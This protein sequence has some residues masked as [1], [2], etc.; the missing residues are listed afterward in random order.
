MSE[1][2]FKISIYFP[3]FFAIILILG[4]LL[5]IKLAGVSVYNESIL[6]LKPAKSNKFS[7][8]LE[9]IN[10][11]Y[12]DSVNNQ[13]LIEQ[14][15]NEVLNDLDPHSQYFPA[16]EFTMIHDELEGNFEGIGVEF[17]IVKDT[18]TVIHA[19][20]GGP[21]EKVGIRGGDRIVLIDDSLVAGVGITSRGA[22]KKLKG[23]RGTHVDVGV[24]RRGMKELLDFTITRDVIP[25]YSLDVAYM[26]NDTIGYIKLSKFSST[27]YH[28]FMDALRKL[29]DEG[30]SALILDLR[31]NAGGYL[32][33][34]ISIADEFLPEKE[35]IV[36]TQGNSRPKNTAHAT[37]RGNF[38]DEVLVI[39]LDES[40]ASSSEVLA[41]AVQDNDR[42]TI[43]GRRSFGK[44]LVQEQIEFADGSALRLTVARY[45]TPTGRCIQRP[46]DEGFED[47]YMDFYERYTNGE[48][49]N[50][51]SIRFS[52]SLKFITKGGNIV[53]GGGGIMP[54]VY[55]AI[56]TNK[57]EFYNKLIRKGL[58]FQFAFDY[59]DKYRDELNRFDSFNHYKND[60]NIS[61]KDFK[62]FLEYAAEN[63]VKGS[64]EQIEEVKSRIKTLMKGYISQNIY[65]DQGFY[66]VFHE[67][68]DIFQAAM[69]HLTENDTIEN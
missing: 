59:T 60:F 30:M 58:I 27:T 23:H 4:I 9:Y 53:Y 15:I 35:L 41:G 16:D 32:Q 43:M 31:G 25:T 8:I 3:I 5:G 21:S 24:F 44:G 7:T 33:A 6:N 18:I 64:A 13:E 46:Y 55:V 29:K 63:G 14:S 56:D 12:V 62:E 28:E 10:Q 38:E 26:V 54:D 65:N 69:K 11:D 66:P 67:I 42:A 57:N 40:S 36:Y 47:Y 37:D 17:R 1:K 51:D 20:P 48:L 45:Y 19:I 50:P 61:N 68:D 34:A 2:K 39:L 22:M 52:D 49:L